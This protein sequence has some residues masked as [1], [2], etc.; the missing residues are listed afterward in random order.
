MMAMPEPQS[1]RLASL[2]REL[3][4]DSTRADDE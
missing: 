4:A 3:T 1:P 2:Q